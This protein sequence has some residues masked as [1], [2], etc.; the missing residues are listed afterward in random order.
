MT[1][2]E[3]A[4]K[5]DLAEAT[6]KNNFTRTQKMF[7]EKY[8]LILVKEGRGEKTDY[9][10]TPASQNDGRA[11]TMT[12]EAKR[13]FMLAKQEFSNLLDFNF[14]VFLGICMT[15]M[16]TFYGKYE[17]FL[18]YVEVKKN[19][20]NL[21]NLKK[22]LEALADKSYIRYEQDKTNGEYFN[23]YL[24]YAVRKEMAISID[25]IQ[26]C[27]R[28]AKENN[29]QSW[30]PLLKTWIGI[31]YVYDKQPYTLEKLCSVTGLSA[32]QVRESK[33][34]LES[35]NLFITSRAYIDYDRCIGS[36]VE[37]NGIYKENRDYIERLH[38][39]DE[40]PQS[41]NIT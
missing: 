13:E 18:A 17:D 29:K 1:R 24:Y 26:R 33:K 40:S 19:K 27:Q 31:Q 23:A 15:P 28:L 7:L 11:L 38:G 41:S 20:T 8:N 4:D 2:K 22:A 9:Q 12:K 37:L 16:G 35:D 36:N 32:Y 39:A 3:L 14:M 5:Y 21:K 25:M 34:I 30:I 6:I 10:V